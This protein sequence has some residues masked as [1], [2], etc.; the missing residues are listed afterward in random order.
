MDKTR[1]GSFTLHNIVKTQKSIQKIKH[2]AGS[3][4]SKIKITTDNLLKEIIDEKTTMQ[5]RILDKMRESSVLLRRAQ[6][7]GSLQDENNAM[8][9][10]FFIVQEAMKLHKPSNVK[11]D[12]TIRM[13]TRISSD[14]KMYEKAYR[15]SL[16]WI[17]AAVES[18]SNMWNKT[19]GDECL[20]DDDNLTTRTQF[21]SDNHMHYMDVENT[22]KE[23]NR[24]REVSTNLED[25]EAGAGMKSIVANLYTQKD[26]QM[27][28]RLAKLVRE[29]RKADISTTDRDKVIGWYHSCRNSIINKVEMLTSKHDKIKLYVKEIEIFSTR[30]IEE[31]DKMEKDLQYQHKIII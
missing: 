24:E 6:K 30:L 8:I 3:V 17:R 20:L 18:M 25:V 28:D 1:V 4:L 10:L 26:I 27:I 23:C 7:A 11:M 5:T 22:I 2:T 29:K 12:K 13:T 21:L 9:S 14:V 16:Y 19:S 15:M 31:L